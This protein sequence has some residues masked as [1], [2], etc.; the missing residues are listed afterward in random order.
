[1]RGLPPVT[2]RHLRRAHATLMLS[3]GVHPKDCLRAPKSWGRGDPRSGMIWIVAQLADLDPM[4]FPAEVD[5]HVRRVFE[6]SDERVSPMVTRY[7]DNS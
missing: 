3:K 5:E 4:H 1:M 6:Q 7:P 2:I